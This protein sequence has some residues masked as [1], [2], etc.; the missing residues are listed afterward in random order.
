MKFIQQTD[1][2]MHARSHGYEKVWAINL[3]ILDTK[4]RNVRLNQ[5]DG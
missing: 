2:R 5:L 1:A 3:L 4:Q